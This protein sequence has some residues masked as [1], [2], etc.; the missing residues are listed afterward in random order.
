MKP[1]HGRST[2][3]PLLLG[4]YLEQLFLSCCSQPGLFQFTSREN[5]NNHQH[6]L[7]FSSISLNNVALLVARSWDFQL[8]K[9]QR[10]RE[11]SWELQPALP[12]PW[13]CQPSRCQEWHSLKS[14]ARGVRDFFEA[15]SFSFQ[16]LCSSQSWSH[17][18]SRNAWPWGHL[19]EPPLAPDGHAQVLFFFCGDA[20]E[21]E[22]KHSSESCPAPRYL[23]S[24]NQGLGKAGK[25]LQACWTWM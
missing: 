24:Q 18:G 8:G 2:A 19:I 6:N 11:H 21:E 25:S 23:L 14:P 22:A 3:N 4:L 17:R 7:D 12:L 1:R 20:E 13:C 16:S 10:W 9:P 5:S 15:L